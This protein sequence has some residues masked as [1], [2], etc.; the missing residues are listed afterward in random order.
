MK[1][2]NFK[3][4]KIIQKL[5]STN[6]SHLFRYLETI[7]G[8]HLGAGG[9]ARTRESRTQTLHFAVTRFLAP[10]SRPSHAQVLI[11]PFYCCDSYA[12]LFVS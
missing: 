1:Y 8:F 11:M 2:N 6:Y 4:N 5:S 9:C 10:T 7:L 12:A 3:E